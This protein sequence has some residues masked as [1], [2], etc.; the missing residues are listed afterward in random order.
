MFGCQ[1]S[2]DRREG[3]GETEIREGGGVGGRS[4][5]KEKGENVRIVVSIF[6]NPNT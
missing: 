2:K 5:R 3:S 6:C 4:S 1:V